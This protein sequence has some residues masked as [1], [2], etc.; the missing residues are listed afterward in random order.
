MDVVAVPVATLWAEPAEG[1]SADRLTQLLLGDPALVLGSDG[2][3]VRVVATDQ[4]A[5]GLDPRG[6]PGWLRADSV[7]SAS[8][9]DGPRYIVDSLHVELCA[10][11]GGEPVLAGVAMGTLLTATGTPHDGWLPV[12]VAGVSA[13]APLPGLAPCTAPGPVDPAAV[14]AFAGR[15]LG[16]PYLWGGLSPAGIDCSGLVHLAWRRYGV[17]LPRDAHDQ[18]ATT[19]PI[20][21]G[22]ERPGDLYFFAHPGQRA[23]HVGFVAAPPDGQ[24]HMLHASGSVL[25]EP[26]HGERAETLVAVHRVPLGRPFG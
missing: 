12:S 17:R 25:S 3:W 16:T 4:A 10:E 20:P 8:T 9:V 7:T 18:Y 26:V 19:S 22:T 21:F 15:L 1:E 24:R 23:H 2:E 14:V 6:Y 11:P 13:W 5:D